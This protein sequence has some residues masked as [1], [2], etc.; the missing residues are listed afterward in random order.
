MSNN[1]IKIGITPG[2]PNGVGY[3]VIIK[4]LLDTSILDLHTPIL[5]ANPKIFS[6]YKKSLDPDN[7][8]QYHLV[9]S[10]EEAEPHIVNIVPTSGEG[11]DNFR[12]NPGSADIAAGS[13]AVASLLAAKRDLD[14]GYIKCVVTGPID[15]YTAHHEAFPF[16]G[17]TEFL[18]T[19]FSTIE[20]KSLMLMVAGDSI[21]APVTNHIPLRLVPEALS[22]NLI[23]EKCILL[24]LA[25]RRDFGIVKPQIA[26]LA[27]NP[28]AGE[29]G[30]LG[31]EEIDI[32][33]PA[34]DVLFNEHQIHAFGPFSPD[35]Y[36]GNS[37]NEKFD[38]TLCM[39]HDQA[40]IPFK[41]NHMQEGVNFT[42]GLN[43]VRTSPDHGTAYD[44]AGSGT[45]DETSFRN[46]L[47]LA[48]DV[49][50][51]RNRFDE[52]VR[53]PLRKTF[54]DKGKDIGLEDLPTKME[55]DE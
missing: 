33:R 40:L 47:Y 34:I 38:A 49:Y 26:I 10:A 46:A 55:D 11:D 2:D 14:A 42:S 22:I 31:R 30:L 5:Y 8:I 7:L 28:H 51:N 29:N 27:L 25:L 1:K 45:A 44:I 36:W 53:N 54:Y 32:I 19:H 18:T 41:I 37:M 3:E 48:I 12:V 50:H 20:N 24:D 9:Q 17:H 43:I 6:F 21:V 4:T 23:V 35:G 13:F 15:K 52:A 39:Y 16:K